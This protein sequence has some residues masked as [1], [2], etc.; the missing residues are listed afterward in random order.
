MSGVRE[1]ITLVVLAAASLAAPM[2]VRAQAAKRDTVKAGK[3]STRAPAHDMAGM[4][5]DMAGMD[6]AVGAPASAMKDGMRMPPMGRGLEMPM[7]PGMQSVKPQ[8]SMFRPGDGVD[9][10]TLPVGVPRRVVQ[11]N[12]GDSLDLTAGLLRRTILGKTYVM[13]GFN[14]QYPGPLI[15]VKQGATITVTFHN[16]LDQPSSIHWHGVRLDNRFDGAVG[17]TQE[18]VPPGGAFVYTVRFVDAGIYWYHPHVRED[19]QQGLGLFGNMMVESPDPNYYSPV[20]TEQF[21]MLDDV[22]IDDAGIFPFGKEAANFAIMGRFGNVFLVNG[23]PDYRLTVRRG[24]VV[25]LFLTDVSNTRMYNLSFGSNPIKLVGADV[26]NYEHEEMVQSIVIAPAQ[27][28]VAE[29]RFDRPGTYAITNRVQALNNFRGEFVAEVDTLG[30]VTVLPERSTSDYGAQFKALRANRNVGAEIDR[31]RSYFPKAPDKELL[32]TVNVQGLPIAVTAFMSVDT[33][34][35]PPAEWADG[36]PDM[37]WAATTKEVRWIMRDVATRKDNMDIDW[38]FTQGDV[39]KIRITNDG[40]SMHPMSHPIHFHG[41]RFLVVARDG[42]PESNLV[43]RDV[44]VLP[45]GSTVDVLL[46]ASNPGRWMAHCHI[47]EHL[48]AGM[49]MAF[50]VDRRP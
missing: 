16:K 12:D 33:M 1:S 9:P 20:N 21:L 28:Y 24:D 3:D 6:H 10:S 38:H 14:G 39:V 22:L 25:R 7:I 43:W 41:Q 40:Q 11:L 8:V 44:V 47:A 48:E 19:I 2:A 5:H 35:F 27:R 34:Y 45:V 46:E 17:M 26:S 37:N 30:T 42:R 18:A 31:Y 23:E 32:L 13:Y 36:M 49:H 50:T 29:V 4:D 15:R